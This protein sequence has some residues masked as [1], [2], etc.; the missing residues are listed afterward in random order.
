MYIY[1]VYINIINTYRHSPAYT[2]CAVRAL[3][4][5]TLMRTPNVP[6]CLRGE[7][8]VLFI[9]DCMFNICSRKMFNIRGNIWQAILTGCLFRSLD[10]RR[11]VDTEHRIQDT[12]YRIQDT[13][14][15]I[16]DTGYRIFRTDATIFS[17]PR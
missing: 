2:H 16:Q 17:N 14:H 5:E 6:Y 10:Y 11:I 13:E 7:N 8:W 1:M 12:G 15:M 3:Q 4:L 9:S